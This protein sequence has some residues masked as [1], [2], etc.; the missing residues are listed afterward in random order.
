[1]LREKGVRV[2]DNVAFLTEKQIRHWVNKAP[3]RFSVTS[4][5]GRRRRQ[6]PCGMNRTGECIASS[7]PA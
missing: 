3:G 5:S 2:E 4:R 6:G 7:L 1:M